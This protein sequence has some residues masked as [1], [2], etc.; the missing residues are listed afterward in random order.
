MASDTTLRAALLERRPRHADVVPIAGESKPLKRQRQAGVV[1]R[2]DLA[3]QG[4][5]AMTELA[6][7]SMGT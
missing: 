5:R 6:S 4:T 3:S 1:R 2:N 7:A